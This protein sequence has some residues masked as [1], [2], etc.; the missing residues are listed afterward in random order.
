M[1]FIADLT[2]IYTACTYQTS[3]GKTSMDKSKS[4][5]E[6]CFLFFDFLS[7]SRS[8]SALQILFQITQ[9][10]LKRL[11]VFWFVDIDL[12]LPYLNMRILR[13]FLNVEEN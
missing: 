3:A 8:E 12:L 10:T 6:Q 13:I 1:S 7:E 4:T 5:R 11:R 2:A 9:L